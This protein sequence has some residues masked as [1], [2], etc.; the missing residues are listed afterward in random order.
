[1]KLAIMQPYFFPYIGYFQLIAAVD[2]FIVYNN[3]QYTK[4]GRVNRNRLLQNG[5]DVIFSL[6]LKND[7]HC[8]DVRERELAGGFNRERLLNQLKGA[9]QCA[10]YFAETFP[11]LEQIIQYDDVN[12]FHFIHHSILKTCEYLCITT[13]IVVSS[14]I[15]IDHSLKNQEKVLAMCAEVGASTYVNAIGGKEMYSR[16]AFSKKGV[17]L[18]FIQSKSIEYEQF[19]E[20]FIPWLSILDV[21]MFNPRDVILSRMLTNYELI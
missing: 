15:A 4:K 6:P 5:K 19:G 9:Y 12:L 8:L 11:L 7:S 21:L 17:D 16:E 14:D 1:M 3:I 2:L 20:A 10:P 13:E 18:K